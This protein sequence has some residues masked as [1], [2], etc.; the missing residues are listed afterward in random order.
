M[1]ESDCIFQQ[2]IIAVSSEHHVDLDLCSRRITSAKGHEAL[3]LSRLR[4]LLQ[5]IPVLTD[6][7]LNVTGA[8][9]EE[10]EGHVMVTHA[11][12][13]GNWLVQ[14]AAVF[15]RRVLFGEWTVAVFPSGLIN[16]VVVHAQKLRTRLVRWQCVDLRTKGEEP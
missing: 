14:V 12:G 6:L 7:D 5:R 10:L 13:K 8:R 3:E 2:C 9:Y 16:H 4:R 1:P 15:P 11:F